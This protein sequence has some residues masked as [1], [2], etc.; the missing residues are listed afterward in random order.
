MAKKIVNQHQ[1]SRIVI[2]G[3]PETKIP[4]LRIIFIW[5]VYFISLIGVFLWLQIENTNIMV[6]YQQSELCDS[7]TQTQYQKNCYE[8]IAVTVNQVLYIYGG[9]SP[10][11]YGGSPSG[12]NEVVEVDLDLTMPDG[13]IIKTS[14]SKQESYQRQDGKGIGNNFWILLSQLDYFQKGDIL[15]VSRWRGKIISIKANQSQF[16]YTMD[17]PENIAKILYPRVG[18][19]FSLLFIVL[20]TWSIY[21]LIRKR[22]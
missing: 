3:H 19:I 18:G 6:L 10:N 14:I 8:N 4:V 16:I 12:S 5:S 7:H 13:D 22:N 20:L 2:Y 15:T 21:E 11:R 17:H 1:I 9:Q